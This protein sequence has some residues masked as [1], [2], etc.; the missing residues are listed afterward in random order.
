MNQGI[1]TRVCGVLGTPSAAARAALRAT[2]AAS[3]PLGDPHYELHVQFPPPDLM[4]HIGKSIPESLN[5]EDVCIPRGAWLISAVSS[6]RE[7][8]A[9]PARRAFINR[10]VYH[11]SFTLAVRTA[12]AGTDLSPVSGEGLRLLR[13]LLVPVPFSSE[14]TTPIACP[15]IRGKLW[16][17]IA[18][19]TNRVMQTSSYPT[20]PTTP[21]HW[22][23]I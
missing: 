10:R 18:V 3:Q 8:N 2:E 5:F 1:A 9:I 23:K 20:S 11:R 13:G 19:T 15:D 16:F 21:G 7:S 17:A 14:L 22:A 4:N 12:M 6:K